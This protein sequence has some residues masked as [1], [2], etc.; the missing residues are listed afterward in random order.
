MLR[1]TI[2]V[3]VVIAGAFALLQSPQ[4]L[5][6][7]SLTTELTCD[8]DSLLPSCMPMAHMECNF[9]PFV[10]ITGKC[11]VGTEGCTPQ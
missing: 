4:P 5:T 1:L 11:K 7:E 6:A 9:P 2:G 3:G 10:W 8:S